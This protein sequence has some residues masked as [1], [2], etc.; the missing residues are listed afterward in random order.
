[1]NYKNMAAGLLFALTTCS[2][3]GAQDIQI[4]FFRCAFLS[5]AEIAFNAA[6]NGN[7]TEDVV[8]DLTPEDRAQLIVSINDQ[9]A[10]KQSELL[11]DSQQTW[12]TVGL[13]AAGAVL[14]VGVLAHMYNAWYIHVNANS[15]FMHSNE[16]W[17]YEDDKEAGWQDKHAKHLCK[18][19]KFRWQTGK[20]VLAVLGAFSTQAAAGLAWTLLQNRASN[21]EDAF[22]E[23]EN[24]QGSLEL[25][26]SVPAVA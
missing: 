24:L 1:M 23:L 7:L 19:A 12:N 11:T 5:R 9:I 4:D 3:L 16:A 13:Y 6:T 2:P 8:N 17:A 26:N 20:S 10:R 15:W 21:H 25:I 14:G 22:I 18:S